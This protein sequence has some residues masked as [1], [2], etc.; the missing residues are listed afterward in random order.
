MKVL[1]AVASAIVL[2]VLSGVPLLASCPGPISN[3][4]KYEQSEAVFIGRAISKEIVPSP[5][6]SGLE[7]EVTLEVEELWK[8]PT[9]PT[10]RVRTCGWTDEKVSANCSGGIRFFVGS[11]YL[12]FAYESPR[13]PVTVLETNECVPTSLL[14]EA[15]AT[16]LWLESKPRKKVTEIAK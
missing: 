16:M 9:N 7:T 8:G 13:P 11:R 3:D 15:Q 5:Y 4:T 2:S 12:V 1:A 14:S 10:L 6:A